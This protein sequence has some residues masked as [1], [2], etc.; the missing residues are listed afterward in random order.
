M[1]NINKE[2]IASLFQRRVA[3]KSKTQ[4]QS[5]SS[6]NRKE[7]DEA[8][9]FKELLSCL[10]ECLTLSRRMRESWDIDGGIRALEKGRSLAVEAGY[11][12]LET[13]LL[14]E[15]TYFIVWLNYPQSLQ[16]LT[17]RAIDLNR[18]IFGP[19]GVGLFLHLITKIESLMHTKKKHS[20][21]KYIQEA[22]PFA[23]D[24]EA[25]HHELLLRHLLV[26]I[27]DKQKKFAL[28]K[29]HQE[30]IDFID[31]KMLE[32]EIGSLD[33]EIMRL[34]DMCFVE[35]ETEF[36]RQFGAYNEAT[37]ALS[38]SST[39]MPTPALR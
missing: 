38:P 19:S 6:K 30:R 23:I 14:H 16:Y 34:E 20:C 21:E 1:S 35:F 5:R 18:E 2:T 31:D 33:E 13:P 4:N 37:I 15:M 32:G 25:Y 11:P 7:K 9:S 22:L 28:S 36:I 29:P 24:N 8:R 26:E 27:Y 3:R 17:S 39:I 12:L 10:A